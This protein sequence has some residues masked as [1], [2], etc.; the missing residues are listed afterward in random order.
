[1]RNKIDRLLFF[2]DTFRLQHA[3]LSLCQAVVFCRQKKC[4]ADCLRR[5]LI[6]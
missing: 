4:T 1:M 6:Y 5:R 2:W 3:C